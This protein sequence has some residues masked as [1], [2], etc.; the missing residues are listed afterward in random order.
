MELIVLADEGISPPQRSDPFWILRLIGP[1]DPEDPLPPDLALIA[2]QASAHIRSDFPEWLWRQV[3]LSGLL[4]LH[5]WP[6]PINGWWYFP[7]SEKSPL[8]SALIRELYWLTLLRLLLKRHAIDIIHWWG[9]DETIAKVTS[10]LAMQMGIPF[11]FHQVRAHTMLHRN[12]GGVLI[13][14]MRYTLAQGVQWAL[15]KGFHVTMSSSIAPDTAYYT[16]FPAQWE[17]GADS[18]KPRMYGM[19]P[20]YLQKKG[21][22]SVFIT[23]YTGSTFHLLR[24]AASLLRQCRENGIE[25][26]EPYLSFFEWLRCHFPVR[27]LFRYVRWRRRQRRVPVLFDRLDVSALWWRE[28]D[29]NALSSEIAFDLALSLALRRWTARVT[30]LRTVFHPFEYQPMERALWAG[31]K[32]HRAITVIGLQAGMYTSNQ[33]GFNFLTAETFHPERNPLGAP[34]PDYLAAYGELAYAVFSKRLTADGVCLSG[35]IRY[36]HLI[37]QKPAD[38]DLVRHP[39]RLDDTAILLLVTTTIAREESL[40]LLEASFRLAK[41]DPHLL[42]LLKCHYLT[43]L[44]KAIHQLASRYRITRYRIFDSNLPTLLRMVP[45]MVTAGSSTAIEAIAVECMPLVYHGWNEMACNPILDTTGGAF[46]WDTPSELRC[47][48]DACLHKDTEYQR[49]RALWPQTLKAHMHPLDGLMNERL[50]HF[51]KSYEVYH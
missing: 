31:V 14:R 51:L 8:R 41:D 48:F 40:Y 35:P 10:Q 5:V 9:P 38:P 45:A 1:S 29:E 13:A 36:P 17:C 16:L 20:A 49:R 37:E 46:F 18:W 27:F 2:E 12:W 22:Q 19:W 23:T 26:I 7:L 50:Y 39:Y 43:P 47:A 33:M 3:C 30:S 15:L 25:F 34:M 28:L 24:R 6:G 32:A 44:H 4:Q 11:H 42:L 21:C